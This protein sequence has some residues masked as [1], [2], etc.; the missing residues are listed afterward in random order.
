MI[1][2]RRESLPATPWSPPFVL[3]MVVFI[4]QLYLLIF[5]R[6]VSIPALQGDFISYRWFIAFWTGDG[7][8]SRGLPFE[9]MRINILLV[10]YLW[11]TYRTLVPG[12]EAVQRWGL[13]GA[14]VVLAV[15][16]LLWVR[17]YA[18]A[19]PSFTLLPIPM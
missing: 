11:A 8:L 3:M 5:L 16:Q 6:L 12:R 17:S 14:A 7:A 19:G 1:R 2:L 18:L 13:V 9:L 15:L 10:V 4:V